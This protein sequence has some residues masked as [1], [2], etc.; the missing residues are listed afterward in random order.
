MH[1]HDDDLAIG[2]QEG[3]DSPGDGIHR[4]GRTHELDPLGFTLGQ[5][6]LREVTRRHE[7]GPPIARAPA[8]PVPV[9]C[10]LRSRSTFT[11]AGEIGSLRARSAS[12]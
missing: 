1:T 6:P 8:R 11:V 2:V 10:W 7:D 12:E 5:Q 4:L 9:N 3:A